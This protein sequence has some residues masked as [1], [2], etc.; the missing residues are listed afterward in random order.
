MQ[1]DYYKKIAFEYEAKKDMK[2]ARPFYNKAGDAYFKQG[3]GDD[4]DS[5][6]NMYAKAYNLTQ[7]K[8]CYLAKIKLYKQQEKNK[9]SNEYLE[10]I[11]HQLAI[12]YKNLNE[13]TL[14]KLYYKK[15]ISLEWRIA[16]ENIKNH[17]FWL[18]GI[19]F[20]K[21]SGTCAITLINDTTC[22][23]EALQNALNAYQNNI[24]NI[25]TAREKISESIYL[26]NYRLDI[27]I[28]IKKI[29]IDE[30]KLRNIK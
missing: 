13:P 20:D 9:I 17:N 25:K 29:K 8:K 1:G 5:A 6:A 10:V 23:K 3:L 22:Q 24:I 30:A 21:I 12:T 15:I 26:D 19:Y 16:K 28:P 2:H 4:Y 27:N 11:Y 14:S 7:T 18:A